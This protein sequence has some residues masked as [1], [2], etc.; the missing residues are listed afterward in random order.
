MRRLAIAVLAASVLA[1]C[2]RERERWELTTDEAAGFGLTTDAVRCGEWLFLADF[3]AK[4]RPVR[5][6]V[7]SGRDLVAAFRSEGC[8][9]S[10]ATSARERMRWP[11]DNSVITGVFHFVV[12][13]GE[14][15]RQN[16]ARQI[17]LVRIPVP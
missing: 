7:A 14:H 6:V 16:G 15:G 5:K 11:V 3:Q 17:T 13:Y 12:D 9:L 10:P 8:A 2:A 4:I 1:S